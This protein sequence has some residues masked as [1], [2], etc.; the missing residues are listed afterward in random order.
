MTISETHRYN[1][2]AHLR[3]GGCGGLPCWCSAQYITQ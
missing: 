2:A 3:Y 1:D